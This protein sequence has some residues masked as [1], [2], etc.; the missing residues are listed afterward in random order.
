MKR[1]GRHFLPIPM[2]KLLLAI[3]REGEVVRVGGAHLNGG[4]Y[5]ANSGEAFQLST[6]AAAGDRFLIRIVV[7][8]RKKPVRESVLFTETG[9][10]VAKALAQ[11]EKETPLAPDDIDACTEVY[12]EPEEEAR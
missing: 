10:L 5:R 1:D 3:L 9:E 8:G 11:I 7:D 2:R 6:V 4:I 12:G